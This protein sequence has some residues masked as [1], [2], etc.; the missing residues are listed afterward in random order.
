MF[1]SLSSRTGCADL[2]LVSL[3]WLV[4]EAKSDPGDGAIKWHG[5]RGQHDDVESGFCLRRCCCFNQALSTVEP[6]GSQMARQERSL[7]NDT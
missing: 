7:R 2:V 6:F 5:F 1:K 3:T 4:C